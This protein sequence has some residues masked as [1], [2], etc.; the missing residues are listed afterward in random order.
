MRGPCQICQC[1]LAKTNADHAIA[2]KVMNA[3]AAGYLTGTAQ[4][5]LYALRDEHLIAHLGVAAVRNS[6]AASPPCP[7]ADGDCAEGAEDEGEEEAELEASEDSGSAS[8]EPS[9]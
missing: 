1:S 2:A 6:K 7:A 8:G 5:G 3:V 9:E 4:Q